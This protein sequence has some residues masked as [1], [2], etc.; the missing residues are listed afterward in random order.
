[1]TSQQPSLGSSQAIKSSVKWGVIIGL[2]SYV[3]SIMIN[4]TEKFILQ[5]GGTNAQTNPGLLIPICLGLFILVFATY[6]AGY[7]PAMETGTYAPGIA[8]ALLSYI[9]SALLEKLY[10]PNLPGSPT[11]VQTNTNAI[12]AFITNVV[13]LI[14]VLL[15]ITGVGWL[16]AFYGCKHRNNPKKKKNAKKITSVPE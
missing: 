5:S 12:V 9:L 2:S 4:M 6:I 3:L 1:M 15:I 14:L 13:G 11:V 10:L 16:G 7:L 8:S